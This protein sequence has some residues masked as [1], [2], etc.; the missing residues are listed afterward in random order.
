MNISGER[1]GLEKFLSFGFE[2][3]GDLTSGWHKNQRKE[4]RNSLKGAVLPSS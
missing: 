2:R 3:E 1:G 4:D